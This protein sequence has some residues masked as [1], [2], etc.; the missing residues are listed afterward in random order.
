MFN[1]FGFL[2]SLLKGI[3]NTYA[4][5]AQVKKPASVARIIF[6]GFFGI[7]SSSIN[8]TLL[9]AQINEKISTPPNAY[10]NSQDNKI[11][12]PTAQ[13]LHN[14]RNNQPLFLLPRNYRSTAITEQ[15]ST[16]HR[17]PQSPVTHTIAQQPNL[18]EMYKQI[19]EQPHTT[20]FRS[21]NNHFLAHDEPP[22][23]IPQP[24]PFLHIQS[25]TSL[26]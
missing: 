9:D 13:Q 1:F 23:W 20:N 2:F 16:I 24:S 25:S 26:S 18:E 6:A 15:I 4:T 14:L 12:T 8:K 22:D 11:T 17:Y 3:Y 5:H 19:I 21:Q 10:D 7:F